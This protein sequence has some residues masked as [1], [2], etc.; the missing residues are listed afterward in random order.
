METLRTAI[1]FVSRGT[2][3]NSDDGGLLTSL[4]ATGD[5]S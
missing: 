5:F 1:E 2:K 3:H 4:A